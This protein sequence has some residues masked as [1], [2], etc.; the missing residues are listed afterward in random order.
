[1]FSPD[2]DSMRRFFME[3]WRKARRNQPVDPL[4]H[5]IAQVIREHPEYHG[6]LEMP[7]TALGRDYH[8]EGGETNPFLHL[9]LHLAI[10]EQLETDRPKGVRARYLRLVKSEGGAHEAEHVIMECLSRGLQESAQSGQPPHER[11]YIAC[12]EHLGSKGHGRTP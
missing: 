1:M 5:R 10:L 4:E 11:S 6:L 12:L 7:D 3:S 8:P 2:R 9:S